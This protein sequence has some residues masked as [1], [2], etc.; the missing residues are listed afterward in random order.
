MPLF[1]T[2]IDLLNASQKYN[3]PLNDVF[4]KDQIPT[5]R[6]GGYIVNLESSHDSYGRK[7]GGSHWVG[8][9]IDDL[10]PSKCVFF[11]PFGTAPPLEI[12]ELLDEFVPYNYSSV[13]IQ[14]VASGIC[15]YYCLFFVFWMGKMKG[16]IP[17]INT[18]LEKFLKQFNLKNPSKNR[19]IL[20]KLL[21]KN[22]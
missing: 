21:R 3:I 18:R 15:G 5:L 13:Q 9:W 2:N 20:D 19:E 14:S 10:R 4:S 17:N 16:K 12:Q 1:L 8:F 6:Q 7:L 22:F 11:D